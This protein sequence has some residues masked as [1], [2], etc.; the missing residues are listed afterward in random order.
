MVVGQ[1]NMVKPVPRLGSHDQPYA[2]GINFS[3]TER[4][5]EE[6]GTPD[7]ALD[8]PKREVPSWNSRT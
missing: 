1:L 4:V 5:M 2:N 7:E 8:M 3:M 6:H